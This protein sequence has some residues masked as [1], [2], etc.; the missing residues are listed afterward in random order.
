MVGVWWRKMMCG[1]VL[2]LGCWFGMAGDTVAGGAVHITHHDQITA[3]NWDRAVYRGVAVSAMVQ[4]VDD[5]GLRGLVKLAKQHGVKFS[6]LTFF[7]MA[8]KAAR[9]ERKAALINARTDRRA[10]RADRL[11][12]K[13]DAREARIQQLRTQAEQIKQRTDAK[14]QQGLDMLRE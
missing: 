8:G 1:V 5:G 12:R 3:E 13:N 6:E 2:G 10:A 11:A 7:Q 4:A 9:L 14:F